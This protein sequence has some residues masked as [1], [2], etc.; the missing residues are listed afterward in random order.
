MVTNYRLNISR[1]PWISMY[2][3]HSNIFPKPCSSYSSRDTVICHFF[4]SKHQESSPFHKTTHIFEFRLW[5]IVHRHPTTSMTFNN[6][7][8]DPNTKFKASYHSITI[9]NIDIIHNGNPTL[10]SS[11]STDS[12]ETFQPSELHLLGF[13][14]LT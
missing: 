9:Q 8:Y 2:K 6:H 14:L 5:L 3:T 12:A 10:T 11:Q 7:L 4:F 1:F 13:I